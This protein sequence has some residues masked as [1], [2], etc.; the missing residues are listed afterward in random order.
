[1]QRSN[2]VLKLTALA[3]LAVAALLG[4]IST[5]QA[6]DNV[7]IAVFQDVP[8][9][10]SSADIDFMGPTG[11]G[12]VNYS[13]DD[14]TGDMHVTASL[15]GVAPD[16]TYFIFLVNGP[17][18]TSASGF[19]LIA[20]LT[21]NIRGNGTAPVTVPAAVLEFLAFGAESV[22]GHIDMFAFDDTGIDFSAGVYVV[23]GVNWTVP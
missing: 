8:P 4:S 10:G 1:M 9:G 2:N 21:T 18:H 7:K 3:V 15:K 6:T 20:A 12:F 16:K 13:Q 23:G 5:A 19:V 14:I 11:F 17:D 22:L